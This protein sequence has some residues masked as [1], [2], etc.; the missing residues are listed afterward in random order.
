M[1]PGDPLGGSSQGGRIRQQ[2]YP[3][4]ARPDAIRGNE[5]LTVA[6]GEGQGR[7]D[8]DDVVQR[9][10]DAEEHTVGFG[11]LDHLAGKACRRILGIRVLDEFDTDE[12]SGA[13][14]VAES[15]DAG[16]RARG[17]QP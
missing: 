14:H 16:S 13:A 10:V 12:E 6:G 17:G 3:W 5:A 1:R 4:A 9:A 8:L 15:C 7:L 2:S 11:P